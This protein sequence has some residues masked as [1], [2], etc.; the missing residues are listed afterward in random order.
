MKKRYR[1]TYDKWFALSNTIT[2]V[3]DGK[4]HTIEGASITIEYRTFDKD[5]NEIFYTKK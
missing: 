2:T 5:G 1:I 3:I 4:S